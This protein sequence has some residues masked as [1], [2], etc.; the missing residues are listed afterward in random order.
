VER[1]WRLPVVLALCATIPAF[2]AELLAAASPPAALLAYLLAALVTGTALVHTTWRCAHRRQHLLANPV[3]GALVAGLLLAAAL[4]PSEGSNAALALRLGVSMLTLLRI[5]WAMQQLITRGGVVY[6]LVLSLGVLGLCGAG[7]WWLEPR[8]P[9]FGD[10]LWLAF[11]TAATVGYGDVVPTTAA[12]KIF[13]VFV[14][15]LGFGV[16]T[17]VTAAIAASW[18]ETEER[19]IE[20]EILRDLRQQ[21]DGLHQEL[22]ALRNE[23]RASAQLQAQDRERQQ[24]PGLGSKRQQP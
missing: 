22:R 10:G 3:D 2:Y 9:T 11:T 15:L 14:V 20:R 19:R 1:A 12:S 21:M 24:A 23:G 13:A 6:L 4:P 5:L 16:L 8:T 18:V 17:M 7:F